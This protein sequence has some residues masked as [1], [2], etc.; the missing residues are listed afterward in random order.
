MDSGFTKKSGGHKA[1]GSHDRGMSRRE[2]L[3]TAAT[4]VAVGAVATS[5]P[6]AFS[7][8]RSAEPLHTIGLGV[9]IIDLIQA[10]ASKDLGF[11]VRVQAMVYSDMF[12]KMLNQ[13]DQYEIAEGYFN[14]RD[15][16]WPAG[17][18]QPIDTKRIKNFDKFAV[19]V[20]VDGVDQLVFKHA[21][22]SIETA[23]AIPNYFPAHHS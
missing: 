11:E 14:D 7:V 18:W 6:L 8:A 2:F 4:A 15:V 10:R 13:N 16:M 12:A 19:I 22:A 20:E 21:I 1:S 17:V 9:S 5:V 3:G 23:R